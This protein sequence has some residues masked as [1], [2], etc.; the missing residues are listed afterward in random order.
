MASAFAAFKSLQ[1]QTDDVVINGNVVIYMAHLALRNLINMTLTRGSC[2][3]FVGSM[4]TPH[5]S[6]GAVFASLLF[7]KAFAKA[8]GS[9]V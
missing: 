7:G 2:A 1:L 4:L 9:L 8:S 3:R 6:T 5:N